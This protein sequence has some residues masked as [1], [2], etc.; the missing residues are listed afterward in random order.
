MSEA[1]IK[2]L[3][4]VFKDFSSNS[5]NLLDSKIQ[6]MNLFKKTNILEIEL[7]AKENIDIKSIFSFENYLEKRFQIKEARIKIHI[8]EESNNCNETIVKEWNDIVEYLAVRHP[9]TK[10]ILN[11]SKIEIQNNIINI[12]LTKKGK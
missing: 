8:D 5:Q 2:V 11:G 1:N 4:E 7:N 6:N 10:A 12:F 3:K 9:I